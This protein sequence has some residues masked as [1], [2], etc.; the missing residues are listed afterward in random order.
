MQIGILCA[1][2]RSQASLPETPLLVGYLDGT[3]LLVRADGFGAKTALAVGAAA[4]SGAKKEASRPLTPN[5]E[6]LQGGILP[7]I[8][9]CYLSTIMNEPNA[10][11]APRAMANEQLDAAA[12]DPKYDQS[13][14]AWIVKYKPAILLACQTAQGSRDAEKLLANLG[15][16]ALE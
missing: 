1:G 8:P 13:V 11:H 9:T 12:R 15:G 5:R 2:A 4:I 16:S 3:T 14:A 10:L 7:A 6:R